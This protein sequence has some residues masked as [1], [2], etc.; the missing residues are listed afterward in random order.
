MMLRK[1]EFCLRGSSRLDTAFLI[2]QIF[3]FRPCRSSLYLLGGFWRVGGS[4]AA[5]SR[6]VS[7]MLLHGF[8]RR[9]E[10]GIY[11]CSCT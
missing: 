7:E 2:R 6:S 3:L 5:C 4:L 11:V 9:L 1:G 10:R 8:F